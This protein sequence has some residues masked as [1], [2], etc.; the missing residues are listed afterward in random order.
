MVLIGL[1]LMT[2]IGF[3]QNQKTHTNFLTLFS[4]E[5]NTQMPKLNNKFSSHQIKSNATKQLFHLKEANGLKQRLDSVVA[6]GS[7]KDE[8]TYDVRGNVLSN[9]YFE[10]DGDQWI[11]FWKDD[12]AYDE[13]GNLTKYV[14]SEWDGNKWVN[15]WKE[16]YAFDEKGN[17]T[18]YVNS[19]WDGNKW[20]NSWKFESDYDDQNNLNEKI[21]FYGDGNDWIYNLKNKNEYDS[22]GNNILNSNYYWDGFQWVNY[23]RNELAYDENGNDTLFIGYIGDGDTW[24]TSGK[25]ELSY[26]LFQNL[27]LY[28]NYTFMDSV[29]VKIAFMES[30]YNEN[31]NHNIKETKYYNFGNDQWE[32]FQRDEYNYDANWN[33]IQKDIF[34]FSEN[35]WINVEKEESV[36]DEYGNRIEYTYS[37]IYNDNEQLLPEWKEEYTYDNNFTF[38]DLILPFTPYDLESASQEGSNII[39]MFK[40]KLTH[41]IFYES[42]GNDLAITGDYTIYYSEHNTTGINNYNSASNVNVFP[43]PATN[44]VSFNIDASINQFTLEFYDLQGKLVMS[45]IG[46]NNTPVSIEILNK[47]LYFY[48]L[49]ENQNLYTGKFMV[50]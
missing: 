32:L 28:E 1:T 23:W 45:K 40:H 15:S 7:D 29:F 43:N 10:W 37:T 8:Y 33:L 24:V 46:E 49:T 16:E 35:Q 14:S 42:Y 19:E 21:D 34:S 4:Q 6:P 18:Q 31:E 44:Q 17:L 2:F 11:N 9:T 22:N 39:L 3:S 13:K 48:R 20:V 50:K 27:S 25:A 26:D 38:E 41:L 12:Y 30:F 36:Y 47:G 5:K